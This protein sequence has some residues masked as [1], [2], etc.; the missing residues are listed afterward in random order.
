MTIPRPSPGQIW[1]PRGPDLASVGSLRL[2]IHTS[3]DQ[4]VFEEIYPT[5]LG[6]ASYDDWDAWVRSNSACCVYS[7]TGRDFD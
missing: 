3:A 6:P 5:S 1:V 4:V 7:L 2:V